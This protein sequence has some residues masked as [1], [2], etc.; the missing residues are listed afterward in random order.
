MN[1]RY[2]IKD[3]KI[4]EVI[5]A[6]KA[7]LVKVVDGVISPTKEEIEFEPKGEFVYTIFEIKSKF[8]DLFETADEFDDEK[9]NKIIADKDKTINELKAYIK[10]LEETIEKL[11][12]E[13]N[14]YKKDSSN[15][16]N[17]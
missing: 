4:Y 15:K 3:G 7:R 8:S 2:I 9:Y 6:G 16:K 10:E 5:E 11:T 17:K 14:E 13:L 12:K 1:P